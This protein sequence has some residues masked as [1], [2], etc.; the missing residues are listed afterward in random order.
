[1]FDKRIYLII[2]IFISIF[3]FSH[4]TQAQTPVWTQL[5]PTGGLPMARYGPRAIYDATNNR[6][7]IFG[8]ANYNGSSHINLNDVWVLSNAIGL[9]STTSSWTQLSPIG[10]PPTARF[11]HTAVYDAANNRMTLFGGV[12]YNGSFYIDLNDVWVLSNANGLDSTTSSWTQIFPT[13]SAPMTRYGHTAVYDPVNNRMMIFGGLFYNTFGNIIYLNDMWVL[14]NANGLD[15]TT[16]AWTQ[17]TTTG[18]APTTRYASTAVYDTTNNRMMIFGGLNYNGSSFMDLNDV[19]VLSNANGLGGTPVWLQLF[20]SGNIPTARD[21]HT[22]VYDATN[23]RMT[24]FGGGLNGSSG[25]NDVWVL[26]H[27]NG[28]GGTPAWTQLTTTGSTPT[29]R[30]DH[31]AI[32]DATNKRMTIFGGWN[33]NALNDVWVLSNADTTDVKDWMLYTTESDNTHSWR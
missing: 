3:L 9:D 27:A 12:N 30:Y 28:L 17:I 5:F 33:G 26:S 20:P 25:L 18:S 6:M 7:T 32:Y 1:M 14:S 13:G 19:W 29:T 15:S 24:I 2:T 10:E 8:G 4:S 16:P 21:S 11:D 23:N 22:A 31:T